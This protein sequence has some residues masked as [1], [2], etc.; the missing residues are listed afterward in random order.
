MTKS[1]DYVYDCGRLLSHVDNTESELVSRSIFLE[2]F[3]HPEPPQLQLFALARRDV[4]PAT[5]PVLA[6]A[7]TKH[8][9]AAQV[10]RPT[11]RKVL[12]AKGSE[13]ILHVHTFIPDY[14]DAGGEHLHDQAEDEYINCLNIAALE[15]NTL[16]GGNTVTVAEKD[17]KSSP[18]K[19][20][21]RGILSGNDNLHIAVF[22]GTNKSRLF[23]V[24]L[25][26][27]RKSWKV[28]R[29][30][31]LPDDL[32]E[33]L[34]VDE[35]PRSLS[36]V[37]SESLVPFCPKGGVTSLTMYRLTTIGTHAVYVYAAYGDGTIIR[38]HH[39]GLFP[40]VWKRSSERG[41]SIDGALGKSALLR[42]HVQVPPNESE[43]TVIPL[44]RFYPSLLSPLDILGSV[45][46]T[47]QERAFKVSSEKPLEALVYGSQV[48]SDHFPA[49][50]FYSSEVQFIR[51][52]EHVTK[53]HNSS[54]DRKVLGTMVGGTK[55]LVSGMIGALKWGFSS[56]GVEE[57]TLTKS[58]E[59]E[60][61]E[62]ETANT[63]FPCLWSPPA[64]LYA[65]NEFHDTPRRIDSC[66]V[67][68]GGR[69]AAACDNF[70]RV[71][72]FDLA[73]KQL[74]RLWKGYRSGRCCWVQVVLDQGKVD[75]RLMIHSS[76]RHVVEVWSLVDFSRVTAV[77]VGRDARI[78][79]C[80]LWSQASLQSTSFLLHSS[81][82]SLSENIIEAVEDVQ[83]NKTLQ[84]APYRTDGIASTWS[85]R[86][87]TLR[88]QRLQQLLSA[89][90][91]DF[92]AEDVYG[93]LTEIQ[94]GDLATAL[95]LIATSTLIEEKLGGSFEFHKTSIEYCKMRL[96]ER[97]KT[98]D[99]EV[100]SN[101]H[102][103]VLSEKVQYH[104]QVR[105]FP[106]LPASAVGFQPFF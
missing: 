27:K 48:T 59:E 84:I 1:R 14:P 62:F 88:L 99:T 25:M 91:V 58:S 34:P 100:S 40:S 38:L 86:N 45:D 46:N 85:A 16:V 17:E 89:T 32:F 42:Y 35:Q 77:Q 30:T 74:I 10:L 49:A 50:V 87:A 57:N 51:P 75:L 79:P 24:E 94:L 105:L 11:S 83:Q 61:L 8:C 69:Y 67:D 2:H 82:V 5:Q 80:T 6:V 37:S 15:D 7:F 103:K 65:S 12:D 28:Q 64:K 43:L 20:L 31:D 81:V 102:M 101:P 56:G 70:G 36:H 54:S 23:S 96:E 92:S 53:A 63:P 95:D 71:L 13:P 78:V 33:V 22:V 97:L 104:T 3:G 4:K 29:Q 26:V 41:L 90:N 60:I 66:V 47:A 19:V 39:A 55:A 93:A 9:I 18:T 73:T 76:H 106:R 68:P 44:P 52:E 72:L 21:L 98:G